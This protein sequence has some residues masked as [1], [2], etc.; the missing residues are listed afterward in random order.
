[1]HEAVVDARQEG[2]SY[3]GIEV[4]T[5]Q[6]WRRYWTVEEKAQIMGESFE[7]G[8]IFPRSLGAMALSVGC[9]G[10]AAQVRDGSE[11]SG[12]RLRAG[13]DRFRE[14][15]GDGRRTGPVRVRA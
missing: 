15:S 3:R 9:D 4:I 12:A 8:L 6:R 2:G 13:P 14:R 11:L 7:E 10:V 1:M 5:G